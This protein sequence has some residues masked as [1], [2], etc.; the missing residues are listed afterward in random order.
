MGSLTF[1]YL[2]YAPETVREKPLVVETVN[3]GGCDDDFQV[4]LDAARRTAETGPARQI[5]DSLQVPM[6]V[7]VFANPCEGEF[8][9]RSRPSAS[10]LDPEGE[11]RKPR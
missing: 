11:G 6:I 4:D 5:S 1:P 9:R 3:S 2:L 10:G 7:P 8:Y